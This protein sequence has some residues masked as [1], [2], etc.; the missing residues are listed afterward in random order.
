MDWN[1]GVIML[2]Q[3]VVFVTFAVLVC[4][5]HNG[6]IN[7]AML[8]ISGSLVGTGIYTTVKG[9]ATTQATK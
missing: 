7:D 4:M 8:A 1:K 5:G 9:K 2:G 3:C 6:A